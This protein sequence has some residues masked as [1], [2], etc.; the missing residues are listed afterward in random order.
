MRKEFFLYTVVAVMAMTLTVTDA[1]ASA[2]RGGG[3]GAIPTPTTY[4]VNLV[5]DNQAHGPWSV[6]IKCKECDEAR[7]SFWDKVP[8]RTTQTIKKTFTSKPI[9]ISAMFHDRDQFKNDHCKHNRFSNEQRK[10]KNQPC[11]TYFINNVINIPITKDNTKITVTISLNG[12][13]LTSSDGAS[14]QY[15]SASDYTNTWWNN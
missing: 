9:F 4:Q 3:G 8:G 2:R 7:G 6:S 15:G 5:V 11:Y 10:L 12:V 1:W 13:S 14:Y